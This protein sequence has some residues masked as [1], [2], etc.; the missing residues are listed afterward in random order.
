MKHAI[1]YAS[2]A[3]FTDTD[4]LVIVTTPSS[5]GWLKTS[6]TCRRN[7]GSSS[8]KRMPWY[9]YNTSPGMGRCPPPISPTS[10]IV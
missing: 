1:L 6:R 5:S 7:S 2:H 4:A 9:A 3:Y 8:R 10:E